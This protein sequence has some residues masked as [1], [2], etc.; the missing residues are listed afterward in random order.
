MASVKLASELDSQDRETLGELT[1]EYA[2]VENTQEI[3]RG[4]LLIPHSEVKNPRGE[5][6]VI[7]YWISKVMKIL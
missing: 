7:T 3:S 2:L 5:G 4:S 6:L 1:Q